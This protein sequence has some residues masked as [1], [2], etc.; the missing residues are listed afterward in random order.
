[1]KHRY[2]PIDRVSDDQM[3]QWF[4]NHDYEDRG[5]LKW[6]GFFLSDHTSAVKKDKT[7]QAHEIIKPQQSNQEMMGILF[8]AWRYY[9][10]VHVQLLELSHGECI[11]SIDGI[12]FQLNESRILIQVDGQHKHTWNIGDLRNVQIIP[13]N[14]I[15]W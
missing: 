11:N 1:M 10:R 15:R 8:K 5:M 14:K 3:A 12:V 7:S 13:P 9:Y 6:Q 4:F 2:G